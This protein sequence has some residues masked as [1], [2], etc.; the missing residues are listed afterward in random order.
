MCAAIDLRPPVDLRL[1]SP[2]PE[3]D[4]VQLAFTFEVDTRPEPDQMPWIWQVLVREVYG[5]LPTYTEDRRFTLTLAPV[6][7]TTAV[8]TVPGV[9][10][11]GE[12]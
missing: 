11:E 2:R 8:D 6:V 5:R 3:R 4:P 12:F 1:P 10:V 9:G 7:V